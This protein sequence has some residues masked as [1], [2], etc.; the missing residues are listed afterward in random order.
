MSDFDS[1]L[2][3]HDRNT[4]VLRTYFRAS[5]CIAR[6]AT[7]AAL[8]CRKLFL[9]RESSRRQSPPNSRVV[10]KVPPQ[11]ERPISTSKQSVAVTQRRTGLR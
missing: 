5:G 2:M 6:K 10:Q 3:R 4:V 8:G 9:I 11:V 1:Q 7:L